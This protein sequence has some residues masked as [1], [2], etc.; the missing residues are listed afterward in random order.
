LKPDIAILDIGMPVLNGF[1]ATRQILHDDREVKDL[2]LTLN[3]SDEVVR[4]V[5]NAGA[6]GF[7]MHLRLRQP[8]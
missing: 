4:T 1:E 7:S 6:R 8:N 5:L 3:H 2:I